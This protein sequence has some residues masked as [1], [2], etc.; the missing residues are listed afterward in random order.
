MKYRKIGFILSLVVLVGVLAGIGFT[1]V[2]LQESVAE[3][4]T[5][6]SRTTADVILASAEISD[7]TAVTVPVTYFDQM[8]DAC[9]DLYDLS[10]TDALSVRQ[11]EWASCGYYNS[12]LEQGMTEYELDSD[13]L[14]VAIGGDLL[15]NRGVSGD[16]FGR[17]FNAVDGKSVQYASTLTLGYEASEARF[18]YENDNFY[19]LNGL[20][21]VPSEG[22]NNDGKNHLFTVNLAVPFRVLADGNEEFEITA[23]D[24]TWVFVGTKLV[25][26]MGGVHDAMTG[27]FMINENREVYAGVGEESLAYSGVNVSED[28]AIVRIFHADRNSSESVF[29]VNLINMVPNITSATLASQGVEGVEVAYDPS[30]PSYV[31]PLGESLTMRP[32]RSQAMMNAVIAESAILV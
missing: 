29:K 27:R 14:P 7:E 31:A 28:S 8:A 19:P 21:V 11:F 30:N 24:D 16:N 5:E 6:V 4:N 26:D 12:E 9:V 22:V 18:F 13:Y 15:P 3:L 32:N 23:D 17:W 20:A 10:M 2:G 1:C 25:L